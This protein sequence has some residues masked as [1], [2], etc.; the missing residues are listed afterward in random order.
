MKLIVKYGGLVWAFVSV[1]Q[2]GTWAA[3]APNRGPPSF[4]S[5]AAPQGRGSRLEQGVKGNAAAE[6]APPPPCQQQ[7]AGGS[8]SG[9]AASR[10]PMPPPYPAARGGA[11][12]E[13][14]VGGQQTQHSDQRPR[15]FLYLSFI[16]NDID[17]ACVMATGR[18]GETGCQQRGGGC[19][20]SSG[21]EGGGQ[22]GC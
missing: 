6:E 4:F 14:R 20:K 19:R 8:P 13:L 10:Q 7:Q 1:C 21:G 17:V 9:G 5:G 3:T 15:T 16:R 2:C 12:G 22:Q 11:S 18:A